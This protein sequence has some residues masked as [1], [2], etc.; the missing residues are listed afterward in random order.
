MFVYARGATANNLGGEAHFWTKADNGVLTDR[1]TLDNAGAF[2]PTTNA[3]ASLGKANF[4]YKQ[5][6]LD[7]TITGTVGAVA[8]SKPAGRAIIALGAASVV[9]TNTLVTANSI[10]FAQL[11]AVDAT[12][13]FIK[14]V[15][16]GAGSFTITGN[17]NATANCPVNFLVI[18]TDS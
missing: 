15:V 10:V 7:F 18:N 9:V 11:A 1:L 13:T 5:L 6:N 2:F 3:G 17:A 4:G 16:A 8:I 14:A 12:L